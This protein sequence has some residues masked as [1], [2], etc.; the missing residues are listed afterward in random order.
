M[1]ALGL[2]HWK[3]PDLDLLLMY[4]LRCKGMLTSGKSTSN[5][6]LFCNE[7][8]RVLRC[9]RTVVFKENQADW[10]C[11]LACKLTRLGRIQPLFLLKINS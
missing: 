8:V 2:L 4:N 5:E 10:V 1:R 7:E 6:G 3:M 11:Q 9:S